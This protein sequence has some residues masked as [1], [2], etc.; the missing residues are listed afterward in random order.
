MHISNN[1]KTKSVNYA[2]SNHGIRKPMPKADRQ[3]KTS[4]RVLHRQDV[5]LCPS[6]RFSLL[7][8]EALLLEVLQRAW[9]QRG[10]EAIDGFG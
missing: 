4:C 1:I 2:K 6:H 8:Y 3:I 7:L 9:M 5:Q 10:T